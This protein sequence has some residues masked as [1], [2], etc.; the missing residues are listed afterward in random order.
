[1]YTS[2]AG[3][4]GFPKRDEIITEKSR[5]NPLNHYQHTK[6]LGENV[7]REF[8]DLIV[9]SIRPPMVFGARSPALKIIFSNLRHQKL[10]FIGSG[11]QQI[12]IAH[13]ADV[14]RLMKILLE[15]DTPGEAYNVVSFICSIKALIETIAD[16]TGLPP[17]DRHISFHLAYTA[18]W[19]SERLMKDP[20]ITRFRVKS[21]GTTR[22]ISAE[23]AKTQLGFTP[24][25]DFSKTIE[26]IV[27]WYKSSC[28]RR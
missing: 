21:L 9:S 11:E 22:R 10:P 2:S 13:P 23:K 6:L 20:T 12:S 8:P 16:L 18:A 24:E 27:C 19:F 5:K 3:V 17:P 28:L 26:E 25:Y 15:K 1:V 14:A 4:Y 7:F